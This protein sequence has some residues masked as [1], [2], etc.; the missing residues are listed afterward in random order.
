MGTF[1]SSFEGKVLFGDLE[2][3]YLYVG[4]LDMVSNGGK[5]LFGFKGTEIIIQL[6]LSS[7]LCLLQS[8]V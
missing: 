1:S 8:V 2:G 7:C 3:R 5:R 4:A 6:M